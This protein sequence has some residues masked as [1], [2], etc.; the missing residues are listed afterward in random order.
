[1]DGGDA[2]S[3]A[4]ATLAPGIRTRAGRAL[5][6]L[7]RAGLAAPPRLWGLAQQQAHRLV[8]ERPGLTFA[9][10][11]PLFRHRAYADYLVHRYANPSIIGAAAL[12]GLIAE[13][14]RRLQRDAESRP[15]RILDLGGGAGH[16][17]FL[18]AQTLPG[19]EVVLADRD[20]SNLYLAGRFLAP[21]AQR[22]CID[23]EAPLPFPDGAF[24]VVFTL[25]SFHYVRSKAALVGEMRRILAPGGLMLLAHL[26]NALQFNPAPGTP[27]A[28]DDYRRILGP[29]ALLA[30][31]DRIID[32]LLAREELDLSL[33][34]EDLDSAPALVAA[35]GPEWLRARHDLSGLFRT[36]G[37]VHLNPIYSLDAAANGSPRCAVRKF[38]S[39]GLQRECAGLDA[40]MPARVMLDPT[41]AAALD[42]SAH[43]RPGLP[44]DSPEAAALRRSLVAIPLPPNYLG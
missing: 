42:G 12:I 36:P 17:S 10:A 41:A 40:Y 18:I 25:D 14:A 21:R 19:A 13:H 1:M 43:G 32:G 37:R 34:D 5:S 16:A 26:H 44:G 9:G 23:A 2:R 22:L 24:E 11:A 33:A 27:L 28:P 20:Y 29:G 35:A 7:L 3:A 8:L 38:P 6:L 31:E 30:R 39:Q 15:L 4:A